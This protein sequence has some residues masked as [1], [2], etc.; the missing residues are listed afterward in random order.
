MSASPVGTDDGYL[1]VVD[2][3]GNT[4]PRERI[5]FRFNPT[6]YSLNYGH[7]MGGQGLRGNQEQV[8]Q[9][10]TPDSTTLSV[11]LLFDTYESGGDVRGE[12]VDGVTALLSVAT[13]PVC[14][15]TW[16]GLNFLGVLQSVDATYTM[17]RR[18]GT[19]VRARVAVTA[20]K[21]EPATDEDAATASASTQVTVT[22]GDTLSSIAESAYGDP[23]AWR[24]IAAA[25]GI[26]NPRA[27]QSGADL[28]I[29]PAGRR[30]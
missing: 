30:S 17:F 26:T 8:S 29:P 2:P 18:D 10:T 21:H 3:R 27:L 15:I 24:V 9:A 14:R 19:P 12:Y 13:P 11:T 22:A 23:T 1:E 25:N 5:P 28:T 20:R 7:G 6:E 16:G 4:F